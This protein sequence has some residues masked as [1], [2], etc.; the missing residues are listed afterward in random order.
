[1]CAATNGRHRGAGDAHLLGDRLLVEA[2]Q[3]A[4]AQD[5]ELVDGHVDGV[6]AG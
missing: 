3:V 5:F 4:Q 6:S 1:M 2:F